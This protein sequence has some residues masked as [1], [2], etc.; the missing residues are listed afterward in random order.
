MSWSSKNPASY[1]TP[2]SHV[3]FCYR[4][5]PSG[6]RGPHLLWFDCRLHFPLVRR[7]GSNL[8]WS[9]YFAFEECEESCSRSSENLS[10]LSVSCL[11]ELVQVYRPTRHEMEKRLLTWGILGDSLHPQRNLPWCDGGR[12]SVRI[13]VWLAF[14]SCCCSLWAS[15][16]TKLLAFFIAVLFSVWQKS[17]ELDLLF[18]FLHIQSLF[19]FLKNA[20]QHFLNFFFKDIWILKMWTTSCPTVS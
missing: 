17:C 3:I 6:A 9:G 15:S 11:P 10:P 14:V 1:F 4:V 7:H 18:F 20:F 19:L 8:H 16:E 5:C 13:L 12:G 2:S